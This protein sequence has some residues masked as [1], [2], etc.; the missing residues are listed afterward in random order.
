VISFRE[1]GKQSAEKVC[2]GRESNTTG[3]KAFKAVAFYGPA[4]VVP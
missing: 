1:R 3:A 2:T 4:K